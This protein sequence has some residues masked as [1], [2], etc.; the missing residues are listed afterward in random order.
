MITPETIITL[1]P[2]YVEFRTPTNFGSQ[3]VKVFTQIQTPRF[4]A[5]GEW[6]MDG[7][8]VR[9]PL[10]L[11]LDEIVSFC[12]KAWEVSHR[13]SLLVD[14]FQQLLGNTSIKPFEGFDHGK[15]D[16]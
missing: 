15:E 4:L 3:V 14:G 2:D 9:E 1:N 6:V 10:S 5:F 11:P 13:T 7:R 16:V 12:V 8:R